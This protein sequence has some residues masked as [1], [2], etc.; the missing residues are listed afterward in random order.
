VNFDA[1][2]RCP[3]RMESPYQP[4]AQAGGYAADRRLPPAASKSG[5][6]LI[7]LMLVLVL[8]V[9][10]GSL[11]IP[12]IN[13]A[14]ASVRL[15]RAGDAVLAHWAQARARAIETGLP[16]QF[17]FTPETG[18]Y[19]LEPW[20]GAPLDDRGAAPSSTTT[21]T[22]DA[23]AAADS[24]D[25]GDNLLDSATVAAKLPDSVVF[26]SGQ[27]STIDPLSGETRVDPLQASSQSAP[28]PILFFPDGA[29][30]QAT[31]VLQ[32]DRS[33]YVRLTIRGLTGVARASAVLTREEMD[34]GAETR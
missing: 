6:T 19:R 15:R 8:L 13:G 29:A 28:T 27:R 10:A 24:H 26:Q 30:S 1:A 7:E 3:L 12:A 9:I 17:T 16:Y 33:Q 18:D 22:T 31:V 32:N 20:T 34:R 25:A 14:F 2:R 23:A 4:P 21:S 5:F 11:A